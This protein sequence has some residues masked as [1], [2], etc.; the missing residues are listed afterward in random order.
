MKDGFRGRLGDD[1]GAV[2]SGVAD[3]AGER[4]RRGGEVSKS[5]LH[6]AT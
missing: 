6:L 5:V 2:A 3:Y 4:V 1:V